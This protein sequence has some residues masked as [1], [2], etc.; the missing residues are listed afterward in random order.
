MSK[1]NW[2]DDNDDQGNLSVKITNKL[3]KTD[4]DELI[5]LDVDDKIRTN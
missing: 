3:D 2:K 4:D 5:K 1:L